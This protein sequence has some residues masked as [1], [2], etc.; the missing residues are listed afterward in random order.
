VDFAWCVLGRGFREGAFELLVPCPAAAAQ[1][2]PIPAAK[3]NIRTMW[4]AFRMRMGFA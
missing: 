1:L 4:V 2:T 3:S